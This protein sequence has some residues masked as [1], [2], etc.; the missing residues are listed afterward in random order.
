MVIYL[1]FRR[2]L[3]G[4]LPPFVEIRCPAIDTRLKIDI[5]GYNTSNIDAAYAVFTPSNIIGLC[6]QVLYTVDEYNEV[7]SHALKQGTSLGLAWRMDSRL[8][9]VW[10]ISDVEGKSRAW[11]ILCGLAMRQVSQNIPMLLTYT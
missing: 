10:Q 2:H 8:D 3:G 7:I 9:W 5:P 6:M 11:S 4:E 1:H